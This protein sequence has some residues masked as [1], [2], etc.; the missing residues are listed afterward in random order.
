MGERTHQL[1]GGMRQRVMIAGA[2]SQQPRLLVADEPTTALDV[3]V[4]RE[5]LDLIL[6][7]RRELGMALILV[8]HDL[9]VIEEVCESVVVMYAGA[10]VEAGPVGAV[11]RMPRHPYSLALRTSRV[12][13]ATPGEDLQAIAGDP[14]VVGAW[15]TGCRFW[16]RCPMADE[17]CRVGHQP[18]LRAVARQSTAC[19]RAETMAEA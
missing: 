3:T 9:S 8:S 12:D 18:G 4:Q 10:T 1:S 14:P 15:P 19:L 2:L 5:I 13:T 17:Q 7:L 16:P 11:V 6:S